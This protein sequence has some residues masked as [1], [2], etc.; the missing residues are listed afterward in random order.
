MP[1]PQKSLS[2]SLLV[3]DKMEVRRLHSLSASSDNSIAESR[4]DNQQSQ[5]PQIDNDPSQRQ[6]TDDTEDTT[7]F[8]YYSG[9]TNHQRGPGDNSSIILC[10]LAQRESSIQSASPP[11]ALTGIEP[12]HIQTQ[13]GNPYISSTNSSQQ[14]GSQTTTTRSSYYPENHHTGQRVGQSM[15]HSYGALEAD[16]MRTQQYPPSGFYPP[17]MFATRQSLLP[18]WFVNELGEQYED[19]EEPLYGILNNPPPMTLLNSPF[20]PPQEAQPVFSTQPSNRNT[21]RPGVIFNPN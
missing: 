13:S 7:N 10:D 18:P 6:A 1:S 5:S 4:Q 15:I 17:S 21:T 12:Y 14:L 20:T 8:T 16:Q 11:R 2:S 19:Y 3:S 9:R